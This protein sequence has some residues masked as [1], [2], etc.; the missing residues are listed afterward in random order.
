MKTL[1]VLT[2]LPDRASAETLAATL[3]ERRLAACVN[4]LSPCRS[5]YRW[6]GAVDTADEVPV[7]I[8]TTEA[9]YGALEAA[10]GEHHPYATPE[11]IAFP[12]ARGLPDYLSWV[13]AQCVGDSAGEN[14]PGV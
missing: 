2:N 11:I 8:K 3:V 10:I 6:Q 5:V 13:A 12:V 7:L 9:R 14:G 1:L 4:I